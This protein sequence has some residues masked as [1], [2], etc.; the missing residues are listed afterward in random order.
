MLSEICGE[1]VPKFVEQSSSVGVKVIA[2][3]EQKFPIGVR[4]TR[5]LMPGSVGAKLLLDV[6]CSLRTR[7]GRD[8]KA[9]DGYLVHASAHQPQRQR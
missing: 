6:D 4:A 9:L 8:V 7:A 2:R 1:A 5:P 3:D